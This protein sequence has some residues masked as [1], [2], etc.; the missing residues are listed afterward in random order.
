MYRQLVWFRSCLMTAVWPTFKTSYPT[1]E[2]EYRL[3]VF[4]IDTSKFLVLPLALTRIIEL[5]KN[6]TNQRIVAK[7]VALHSIETVATSCLLIIY[8]FFCLL[9]FSVPLRHSA[10]SEGFIRYNEE[11]YEAKRFTSPSSSSTTPY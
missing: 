11:L 6:L 2:V 10:T 1:Y 7:L 9:D 8:P 5:S 3:A 4:R